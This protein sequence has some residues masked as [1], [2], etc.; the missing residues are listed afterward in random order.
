M[1]RALIVLLFAGSFCAGE[2][3]R[4]DPVRLTTSTLLAA[5]HDVDHGNRQNAE[6]LGLE[7]SAYNWT[8]DF[9]TGKHRAVLISQQSAS[10]A[11]VFDETGALIAR[12]QLAGEI[13]SFEL[14][15]F[16]ADGENEIIT[17][18]KTGRGTGINHEEIVIYGRSRTAAMAELWRGTSVWYSDPLDNED[19]RDETEG[20][21]RP[22]FN[23]L[24]YVKKTIQG[25]RSTD[26][27]VEY[28]FTNHAF[29]RKH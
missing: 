8:R 29:E 3:R 11:L 7:I 19:Q 1:T 28:V 4:A 26:E 9:S 25:D 16:D 22:D 15:D 12:L 24:L 10:Y 20:F 14:F 27:R 6:R 13:L 21:V 23:A 17:R 2:E 18:Q 5:M